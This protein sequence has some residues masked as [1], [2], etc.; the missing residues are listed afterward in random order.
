MF[1]RLALA[2]ALSLAATAAGQ[3]PAKKDQPEKRKEPKPDMTAVLAKDTVAKLDVPFGKDTKQRLDVYSPKNGKGLP[4]V[5]YI[6]GGEWTKGDKA[7]VS[8]KPK[9]FNE[10]GVVFISTNY[11]LF[12]AAKFPAHAEDVAAAVRWAVDHVA[13][14]G[15]DPKKIVLMGHSAGCH[16]VTL[17]ALDPTYLAGVKLVPS[18]LRAVVAWS[19]GAYDLVGKV[20]QGGTYK[21]HIMNAFGP[22]EAAWKDASP[23]THARNAGTAAPFLFAAH[24]K[25]N[26]AHQAA[27]RLAG[28]IRDAKG[29]A[30]V[31][32][33][34]GRTHT[35]AN[36]L[37]GAPDDKTGSMLL[38]FIKDS[39][40]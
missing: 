7:E 31:V 4:V 21:E 11:R 16:L 30:N 15:G 35:T 18:D 40:K 8:F 32:L 38:K 13:E 3:Q 14:Y 1:Y 22:E 39:T 6:H 2:A 24:E 26:P 19:G 34:E 17:V 33:L 27:E 25:G 12:P 5:I 28:L 37:L 10:N 29:Q 23:V 36:H 9:F 20:K